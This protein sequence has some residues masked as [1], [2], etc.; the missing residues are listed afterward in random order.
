MRF[1][2][3][4]I[5]AIS[6]GALLALAGVSEARAEDKAGD[7]AADPSGTWSWVMKGRQGRPDRKFTAKL[8]VADGKVTGKVSS[9][10]RDG[11]NTETEITDGKVNG[12]EISFSTAREINGNKITS[13]YTGKISG[14]SIKGTIE[15]ERNGEPVKRDWEATRG[16]SADTAK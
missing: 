15:F 13:K 16:T 6:L 12:N 11:E 3:T 4:L 1:S 5:T 9:P 7:K 2:N 10:N 8:K 14:D